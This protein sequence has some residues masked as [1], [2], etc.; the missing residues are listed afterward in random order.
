MCAHWY[1]SWQ[2]PK[3]L[4]RVLQKAKADAAQQYEEKLLWG[5]DGTGRDGGETA[6]APFHAE[7]ATK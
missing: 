6:E 7:E 4:S 5:G 2:P 1:P 3:C